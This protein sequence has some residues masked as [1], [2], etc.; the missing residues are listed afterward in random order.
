MWP[1][2]KSVVRRTLE[3][4]NMLQQRQC[5]LLCAEWNAHYFIIN[6]DV[7]LWS[8]HHRQ[9]LLHVAVQCVLWL[10]ESISQ[11]SKQTI[12]QLWLLL[13]CWLLLAYFLLLHQWASPVVEYHQLTSEMNIYRNTTDTAI[14]PA[15]RWLL[16]MIFIWWKLLHNF[17]CHVFISSRLKRC[18]IAC[19]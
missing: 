2:N 9:F 19:L 4:F 16:K 17:L 10:W 6:Y 8:S 11:S 3:W 1:E 14:S 12:L 5:L 15:S 18:T 7:Y 13:R